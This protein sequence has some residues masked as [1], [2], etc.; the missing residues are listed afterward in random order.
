MDEIAA[1]PKMH[2]PQHLLLHQYLTWD[3]LELHREVQIA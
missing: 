1:S 3:H 2:Y